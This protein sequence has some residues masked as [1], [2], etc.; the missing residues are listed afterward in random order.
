MV[1]LVLIL[2]VILLFSIHLLWKCSYWLRHGVRGP[3]SLPILGNMADFF[4]GRK[5]YGDVY[6]N[7][8]D[9]HPNLPYV[10][11]YR[12]FNEP[13]I[14]L[15]SQEMIKEVMIRSFQHFQDNVLWISRKRD[16]IVCHNPFI[17]KGEMWKNMRAEILPI[18]TPNKVKAS[19]PHIKSICKKLDLFVSQQINNSNNSFEA[20]DLLSKYTLDVVASAGFGL[21]GAS[22]DNTNSDFTQLVEHLFMPNSWSLVETIALLFSPLLGDIINYRYVPSGVQHW[23]RGIIGEVLAGRCLQEEPSKVKMTSTSSDFLQW[24]IEGRHKS[25]EPVDVATMVGHCSTFLLEGFETSS[26]LMAFALYE[27]A[28]HPLV[29]ARVQQEIDEVLARHGGEMCYDAIQEMSYLGATLYE[30]LRLYPAMM[31]LLKH[32]TKEFEL[33]PQ[34]VGGKSFQVPMGMVFI[35]PVKA[36]HYDADLYEDPS[37]FQPDRFLDPSLNSNRSLFL[38]FGEGPRMCPGTRFGLAQSKAGIV[39]LLSKYSVRL[40]ENSKPFKISAT[41]FLTAPKDGIW[42]SFKER[43]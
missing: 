31:A 26:S 14:L 28:K 15:R 4:L 12:L 25:H 30:T 36:I 16:P 43:K 34:T 5:H 32:C 18:F 22:F 2:T 42:I 39:T 38:G 17:A 24:L 27:Y 23:L 10:G 9:A 19:F 33:P 8:Y 21:D 35:V 37:Q 40:S 11:I 7:L 20:K 3:C 1:F 29:Q 41:T 13:A 6:K